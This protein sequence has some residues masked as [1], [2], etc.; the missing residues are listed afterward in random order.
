MSMLRIVSESGIA[1]LQKAMK[2]KKEL[3]PAIA[4]TG[5]APF[6]LNA[7]NRTGNEAVY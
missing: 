1:G 7:A 2:G 5:L 4:A 6:L 3:L